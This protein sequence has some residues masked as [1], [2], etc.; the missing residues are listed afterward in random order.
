MEK[1]ISEWAVWA[2]FTLIPSALESGS[3]QGTIYRE[4]KSPF[5]RCFIP[6]MLCREFSSSWR[7]GLCPAGTPLL[8]P[9]CLEP[10]SPRQIPR[11]RSAP[12]KTPHFKQLPKL[13]RRRWKKPQRRP[14]VWNVIT[15]RG[16]MGWGVALTFGLVML[17][18]LFHFHEGGNYWVLAVIWVCQL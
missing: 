17:W 9:C 14:W 6:G 16:D 12:A 13:P 15:L 1:F 3:W 4:L 10:S 5:Y 2:A 18:Q 8:L 11:S 7:E